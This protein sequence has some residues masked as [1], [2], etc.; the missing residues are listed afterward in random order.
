MTAQQRIV[1]IRRSYNQWVANQT[2]EDYALRFTAKSARRWSSFRVANT[3]IGAIS[4]LALEAIGGALTVKY[5]FTNA[6]SAILVVGTIIFLTGLP[7]AYYASKYG[8]DIDLLTRGAGFG[9]IGSTITSLIYASFTFI[10]F[11][12]E[13]AIMSLALE[14]CFGIPLSVGYVISSLVVIPLVTHGITFISRLQLWTQPIWLALHFLPFAFIAAADWPAFAEWT[15]YA[16]TPGQGS[17]HFSLVLFGAGATVVFSLVAQIGEQVDFLRFLPAKPCG[18]RGGWWTANLLAGPGWIVPGI[19]KMLAGS[20]L[21][22][23][24]VRQMVPPDRAAEPTQMYLVAF[25]YVFSSPSAAL[26]FTGAF[27]IV[28]QIKINVTNAYA[29]SIAWSNFFSRLTHSHPGRVVWLVFNVVIAL[30]L[31]E[32]GI[33]KALEHILGLYSLVAIGWVGSLVADLVINKP[34]GLSPPMIEFKRAHLYDINPV[35][36]GAMLLATLSGIACMFGLFGETLEPLAPFVALAVTFVAAPAIAWI[37][38]GQYYIARPPRRDWAGQL[39]IRCAICE[40]TFEAED[41]AHCPAYSG[42]ICSLCCS[43]ETR[44]RD[45]CKPHA[46]LANQT[47]AIL[48]KLMPPWVLRTLNTDVGH[49]S[50]VLSLF[51]GV[52]GLVLLFVYFQVSFDPFVNKTILRST[53]WTV[54]FI[55]TIVGG[56]AA[57]L[58]VLA[59]DSRR[60]AEE[61]TR[62]QTELLMREIE[63]H[64]R[65]DAKLQKA[66]EVAEAAN[67]AK[68]R[69]VAG[70]SH[71]LRTP[72]NSILGYARILERDPDMPR[73]RVD[74]LKVVRRSAEHLSGLI[75]GLLDIS[76]IEAGR[77]HLNRNEVAF[78]EFIAQVVDM[79]R[80]Q[81]HAKGIDF[82]FVPAKNMPA[83]VYTDENRLRQILINLLSNAIKFTDRG[84]VTLRITYRNQVARFDIDDTGIGID[85]DD[86]ERIFQPFERA[87]SPHLG[88]TTG[89]GLGLTITKLLVET[90]GG[91]ITVDSTPR[92]GS[93]FSVKLLLSEVA[94]PRIA[95]TIEDQVRG[96]AGPRQTVLVVDDN[97]TQRELIEELLRPLGFVVIAAASGVD[98]LALVAHTAPDLALV[99]VSMPD[100]DGWDLTTRLRKILPERCAII[101]LSALAP[102]KSRELA[103]ERVHDDY[104]MKPLDLRLL[105]EKI[106]ALLN[107]EWIYAADDKATAPAAI[108]VLARSPLPPRVDIEAL[109]QLGRI[110][111]LRGIQDKLHEIQLASPTFESFVAQLSP[112]V[113]AVDLQ[114]LVAALEELRTDHVES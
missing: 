34:L 33:F 92:S 74:A 87:H 27:V 106:H 95:S 99:D 89:T 39:S 46:R 53:L 98:A 14:L 56:I 30:L 108:A 80:L 6:T 100:M 96:Y 41:M 49:Y 9:Y 70:L 51:A 28:S 67:N 107:I 7:I 97:H 63:A 1:R 4:F 104:L 76:K 23:L 110:G 113:E 48:D 44:C 69:H 22:F 66:K 43:L 61:E 35:G 105:L 72:L 15:R 91:Q 8:V 24:A 40:H 21:A 77:F 111:Q 62:R 3:A 86:I 58:F 112:M 36:V 42:P 12:I 2:L 85:E 109:I 45:S 79:F 52:I 103:P 16:G 10:F 38:G 78:A 31:M 94:R 68:S 50:G 114:R 93:T 47:V 11:A 37:T 84:Q 5:G 75:D 64:R 59:H 18:K 26:V 19:L 60:V 88:T 55:L 90:M 57:W 71:E 81:A 101:M 32:L 29:G 20:F 102:D 82:H 83:V 17:D 65:T 73:R 13:A 25:Q 54:F